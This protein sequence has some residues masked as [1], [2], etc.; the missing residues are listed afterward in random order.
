MICCIVFM[1]PEFVVE[2][3]CCDLYSLCF[4]FLS[5]ASI[6]SGPGGSQST[7]WLIRSFVLRHCG[8]GPFE[9]EKA[10]SGLRQSGLGHIQ[11]EAERKD[12]RD[13]EGKGR[14]VKRGERGWGR[15]VRGAEGKRK[16]DWHR[17]LWFL[18]E[19]YFLAPIRLSV[20]REINIFIQF[21][22]ELKSQKWRLNVQTRKEMERWLAR[23]KKI[24]FSK[25]AWTVAVAPS[26]PHHG[27]PTLPLLIH[28]SVWHKL[29]MWPRFVV[30]VLFRQSH[31]PLLEV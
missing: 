30:P 19:F 20:F 22:S 5:P 11:R 6:F 23:R 25:T 24:K 4:P 31:S 7:G 17:L 16:R 28:C 3:L 21:Y 1:C 15:E 2:N 10:Y 12:N 27:S 26:N 9:E 8:L 18:T 13:G 29:P 14:M